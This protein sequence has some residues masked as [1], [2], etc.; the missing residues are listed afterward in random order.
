MLYIQNHQRYAE[1]CHSITENAE[2]LISSLSVG[3]FRMLLSYMQIKIL[4]Y[5]YKLNIGWKPISTSPSKAVKNKSLTC[6]VHNCWEW[7]LRAL[8]SEPKKSLFRNSWEKSMTKLL[9]VYS[10]NWLQF[11]NTLMMLKAHSCAH[12]TFCPHGRGRQLGLQLG[13][14]DTCKQH[15]E[16]HRVWAGLWLFFSNN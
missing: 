5:A 15:L 9:E 4:K 1:S 12:P 10:M 7:G 2:F 6:A 3:N 16:K 13:T 8:Q 11:K 14:R